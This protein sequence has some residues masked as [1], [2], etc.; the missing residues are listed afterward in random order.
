MAIHLP[1][2]EIALCKAG[3]NMYCRMLASPKGFEV[4]HDE[5]FSYITGDTLSPTMV[6]FNVNVKGN[7]HAA[8]SKM[9]RPVSNCYI[10]SLTTEIRA[11]LQIWS[12]MH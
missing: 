11:S 5:D 8:A 1:E 12:N 7:H 3:F 4:I 9:A 2:K 6:I 10:P